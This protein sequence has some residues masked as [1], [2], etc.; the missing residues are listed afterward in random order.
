MIVFI[1][2][3]CNSQRVPNKNFRLLKD[4]P[5]YQYFIDRL[6]MCKYITQIII[7]TDSVEIY[8]HYLSD[9][10]VIVNMRKDELCGDSISVCDLILDTISDNLLVERN[11]KWLL[12]LHITTPY[13]EPDTIDDI[14]LKTY[15]HLFTKTSIIGTNII[16]SRLWRKE[17]YGMCPI[18]HNPIRLEQTQDLPLIYEEN[19]AF[20]LININNF[21][22][23]KERLGSDPEFYPMSF[24]ENIDIDNESDWTLV[25]KL[26]KIYE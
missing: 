20:Y 23:S 22:V 11:E 25:K 9:E 16:Q 12:Q 26:E 14:V 3:K 10:S 15:N 7:N 5:L 24:P 8:N 6:K 18:N 1:P 19:S 4:K 21:I 17:I 13:L 2:I